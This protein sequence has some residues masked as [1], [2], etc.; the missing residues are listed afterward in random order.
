VRTTANATGAANQPGQLELVLGQRRRLG[1]LEQSLGVAR[2][3]ILLFDGAGRMRFVA[4]VGL[5]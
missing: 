4:S 2:S 1:M 3:A 5:S